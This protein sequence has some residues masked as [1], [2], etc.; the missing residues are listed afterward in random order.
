M[1][2]TYAGALIRRGEAMAEIVATVTRTKFGRSAELRDGDGRF[3]GVCARTYRRWYKS[4]PIVRSKFRHETGQAQRVAV[5]V[6]D[7]E[8]GPFVQ[9]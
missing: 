1:F 5:Y 3:R 2:M 4:P 6:T 8:R 7:D 9:D